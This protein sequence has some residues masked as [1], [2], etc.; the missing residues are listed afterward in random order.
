MSKK[1]KI[2]VLQWIAWIVG[3]IALGVIAFGIIK[4]LTG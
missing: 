4:T 2:S 1:R 3:L